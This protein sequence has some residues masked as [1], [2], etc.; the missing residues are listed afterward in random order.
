MST[1]STQ[2]EII[3]GVNPIKKKKGLKSLLKGLGRTKS[4]EDSET[5]QTI[6]GAGFQVRE[7]KLFSETLL[8][9]VFLDLVAFKR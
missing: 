9:E 4:I 1:G 8:D 7:Q 6:A 3:S 5:G 2:S